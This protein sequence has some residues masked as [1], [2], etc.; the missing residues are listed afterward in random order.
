M[1]YSI[2]RVDLH[3]FVYPS[4]QSKIKLSNAVAKLCMRSERK[5]RDV[6]GMYPSSAM[7]AGRLV[8]TLARCALPS[9]TIL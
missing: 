2:L 5:R 6:L 4:A 8:L 7:E 3:M 9:Y 1:T